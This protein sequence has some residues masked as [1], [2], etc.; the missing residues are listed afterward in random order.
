LKYSKTRT[1]EFVSR[2]NRFMAT[3]KLDGELIACHVKNTGRCKELLVPGAK[4]ILNESDNLKR[5]TRYDLISVWKGERLV[6]I[7][8]QAPNKVFHEWLEE[9]CFNNPPIWGLLSLDCC[10]EGV[11]GY[12]PA[13]KKPCQ[14]FHGLDGGYERLRGSLVAD[15]VLIKPEYRYNGSRLDFYIEA[16]EKKILVEVKGVTLEDEGVVLFPDAPTQ[17]GVKH[18]HELIEAAQKGYEAYIVFII[19]MKDVRYFTPNYKTH[20]EFG[21][22]L[23]EAAVKGV[24]IFALDCSVTVDGINLGSR[25]PVRL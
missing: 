9:A 13:G 7:D 12:A 24:H 10:S 6:N 23:Q 4:V 14:S 18:I 19:Q 11:E 17:R 5:K 3:V 1:A 2:S 20:A 16:G 22:A 15:P 21:E 8:S 25:V